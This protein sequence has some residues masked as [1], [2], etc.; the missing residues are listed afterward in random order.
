MKLCMILLRSTIPDFSDVMRENK[1]KKKKSVLYNKELRKRHFVLVK[2][3]VVLH[4]NTSCI[5]EQL[6][7][8]IRK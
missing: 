3:Y 7:T 5:T 4:G 1:K 6:I 8:C 2:N